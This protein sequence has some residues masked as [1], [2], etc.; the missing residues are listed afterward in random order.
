MSRREAERF[1]E[2]LEHG[3]Q[4][5]AAESELASLIEVSRRASAL[6]EPPPPPPHRLAPGRQHLLAE[7]AN[8]RAGR[9]KKRKELLR[10]SGMMKPAIAL[11]AILLLLGSAF[12]VSQAAAGSL[13][14]DALYNLKLATEDARVALTSDPQASADLNLA[15]VEERLDEVVALLEQERAVDDPA[16]NRVGEQLATALKAAVQLDEPEA[17]E[18]LQKLAV[19]IQQR[20]RQVEQLMGEQPDAPVRQVIR[21]MQRVR[22]EAQ[23]NAAGVLQRMRHGTPPER[24]DMPDPAE[25]PGPG[26]RV[27]PGDGDGDGNDQ[28]DN[29][30]DGP[31]PGPKA[32]DEAPS[33]GVNKPAEPGSKQQ[34][35][36]HGEPNSEQPPA[37]SGGQG[38]GGGGSQQGKP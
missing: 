24:E 6:A 36:G 15:L 26:P 25:Q 28:G 21:T 7:T 14:G 5:H 11:M 33:G 31:G 19:T 37:N 23:D 1:E 3:A 32:P 34:G 20:Q 10:M 8:F 2:A 18:T 16:A 12:G 29:A 17:V 35:P 4:G 30:G 13:P 38:N 27:Q 22:T 9:T